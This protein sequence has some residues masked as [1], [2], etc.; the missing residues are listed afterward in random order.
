VSTVKVNL[1]ASPGEPY[2]PGAFDGQLDSTLTIYTADRGERSGVLRSA[3]V[4]DA[5]QAVELT[6]EL[7]DDVSTERP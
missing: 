1:P 4:I 5:G 2:T 3:V 6:L 7:P